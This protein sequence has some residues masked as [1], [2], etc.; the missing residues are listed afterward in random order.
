MMNKSLWLLMLSVACLFLLSGCQGQN[1]Q[2]TQP[3][4]C[5][6]VSAFPP[7]G[8]TGI[9]I[10]S[11]IKI[12]FSEP[13]EVVSLQNAIS[14]TPAVNFQLFWED[15]DRLLSI[16]PENGL[17]YNASYTLTIDDSASSLANRRL[18]QV[19]ILGFTTELEPPDVLQAICPENTETEPLTQP[20]KIRFSQAMDTA[21]IEQSMSITPDIGYLT[22]WEENDTVLV[23]VPAPA[24]E[25]QKEYAL[26]LNTQTRSQAG[27]FL[28]NDYS[29]SFLLD[30]IPPSVVKTDLPVDNYGKSIGKDVY[31][32]FSAPMDPDSTISGLT[33][34]PRINYETSW[35]EDRRALVIHPLE[36]WAVQ[37]EYVLKI[38]TSAKSDEGMALEEV[39]STTFTM[40]E[41]PESPIIIETSPENHEENVIPEEIIT[42][43]FSKPMDTASVEQALVIIPDT[44]VSA[45]L[46]IIWEEND[47]LMSILFY[48]KM[49]PGEDYII[50][51]EPSAIS[52][53]GM[54]MEKTFRL[55]F[56]I[57]PC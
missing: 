39:Y 40:K 53:D 4:E 34:S 16:T 50:I 41:A 9:P 33:L 37:T 52:K 31:I 56:A 30:R 28:E 8:A 3:P 5:Q 14:L 18:A 27:A 36:N 48:Q 46:E 23:V 11:T 1:N 38:E 45:G 47:T 7:D 43:R 12:R 6:V 22:T 26:T 20:V 54:Y 44:E 15:D 55:R 57:E 10:H 21:S 32:H 51:I 49:R 13:M 17:D 24:W 2:T 35:S 19:Y 42:I 25:L 29:C